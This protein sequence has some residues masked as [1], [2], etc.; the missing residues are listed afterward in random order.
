MWETKVL[1]LPGK[2]DIVSIVVTSQTHYMKPVST[3][4]SFSVT[5]LFCIFTISLFAQN[6]KPLKLHPQ[7]PH[8]FLYNNKSTILVGS[9]EHYGSVIN[10]DFNYKQYLETL[11]KDGLNLTRLFTG[12]YV[13]KQGDF[14]IQKNIL[15]PAE[16]RILLPWQRSGT[17]GYALGGNKF[18][19]GK[20]DD[21]YFSR[22]KDFVREAGKNNVIVEVS[23]F[24]SYY[25][26]GWNYSAL[27]PK[28][29]INHTDS[30]SSNLVNTL[31]NGNIL[32]YQ[33]RYV[34]KI[35]KELNGFDNF[36]FEV[37]NEPW[38]DQTDT[39]IIRND[40]GVENDWRSTIQ[41]VSKKSNE[42]QRQIA[43]WLKEEESRLSNKHLISQN[44]SNYHY[45][46]TNPDPN[47]SI[48]NFHYTLPEAAWENYYL[49]RVMGFNET[50]FAGRED[51]TYRK[52]AWRF[53]MAGGGLFNQLDY[54]FSVGSE[55]G[56]DTGYTAPGGG[57]PNLRRQFGVLKH[58]FDELNF[59]KLHPDH[60]I[61]TSGP[62]AMTEALSDGK[63]K[64]IIYLER[65]SIKPYDIILKLS[66]S[67][68]HAEWIDV[69]TGLTLTTSPV[70]N[71]H[72]AVPAG[73]NDMIAVI[74]I[75]KNKNN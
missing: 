16:G 59:V 20:W 71:G 67:Q 4:I 48:F 9:G 22:L 34:R 65:Q 47:I 13:E 54:S 56:Q 51:Q 46:I 42:W 73:A 33:E 3:I 31:S 75:L 5:L 70:I 2:S 17:P 24:S 44:I 52:Q 58:F 41:V 50:G 19:L 38:A 6:N 26:G 14:G 8:Y 29:N 40:Y 49:N 72:L 27:N 37:Q 36:Y 66:G 21:A 32:A 23:L 25:G 11:S 12:A 55:N 63:I 30:I 62:G 64:W 7:N 74:S 28:N 15:A 57:S 60:S 45:P 18:D 39:V 68:Y 69:V 1:Q 10:E 35:V 43:R 53:L 61:I